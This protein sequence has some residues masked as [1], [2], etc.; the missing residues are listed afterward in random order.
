MAN[1]ISELTKQIEMN[2]NPKPLSENEKEI[3]RLKR[4]KRLIDL[5]LRELE[6]KLQ[7]QLEEENKITKAI[8]N[9]G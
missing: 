9:R 5:R 3:E 7:K 4:S 8:Q 6:E 1:N 2:L